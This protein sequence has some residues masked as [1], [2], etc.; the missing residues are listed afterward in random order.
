MKKEEKDKNNFDEREREYDRSVLLW[1]EHIVKSLIDIKKI[2]FESVD[3]ENID[4]EIR[5]QSHL[6]TDINSY[7]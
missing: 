1:S 4:S 7:V 3:I 6:L 5:R 2:V